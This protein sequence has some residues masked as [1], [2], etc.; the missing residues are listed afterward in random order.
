MEEEAVEGKI[1]VLRHIQ[2]EAEEVSDTDSVYS[3]V[4]C[5]DIKAAMD[6]AFWDRV[7][8]L[9]KNEDQT[10]NWVE[11]DVEGLEKGHNVYSM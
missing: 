4:E 3:A 6:S 8:V 1:L 11:P 10:D 2:E 7:S 9:V 5:E